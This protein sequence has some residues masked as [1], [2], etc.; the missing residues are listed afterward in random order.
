MCP[1]D[2]ISYQALHNIQNVGLDDK[3]MGGTYMVG[4]VWTQHPSAA[5]P[6][7]YPL[8]PMPSH[9][10]AHARQ[11]HIA[12]SPDYDGGFGYNG[13]LRS[14]DSYRLN[15]PMTSPLPHST[16]R[17]GC[18]IF[19]PA[20]G[21]PGVLKHE[22]VGFMPYPTNIHGHIGVEYAQDMAYFTSSAPSTSSSSATP[23]GGHFNPKSEYAAY[24]F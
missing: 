18:P 22:D 21:M 8:A 15:Y 16:M 23:P 1:T 2:S 5:V 3:V 17:F 14:A 19:M 9:S 7:Y 4:Q 10:M 6:S 12:A 13:E 20:E 11:S 24:E